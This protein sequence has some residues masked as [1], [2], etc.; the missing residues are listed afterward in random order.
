M[1][2]WRVVKVHGVWVAKENEG[3]R[4][5]AFPAWREAY[6]FAYVTTH[7]TETAIQYML[8]QLRF[9]D[10]MPK[11]FMRGVGSYVPGRC[12]MCASY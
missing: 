2:K 3:Y 9:A 10:R 5:A 11:Y 1:A 4:A 8:N 12:P 6:A 7:G